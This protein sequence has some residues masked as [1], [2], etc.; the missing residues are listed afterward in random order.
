[1]GSAFLGDCP[2]TATGPFRYPTG[3]DHAARCAGSHRG[4]TPDRTAEQLM[5]SRYSAF[6]VGDAEYAGWATWHSMT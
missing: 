5:R 1:M 6:A 3:S 2:G 4:A